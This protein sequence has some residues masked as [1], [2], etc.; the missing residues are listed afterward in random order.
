[1]VESITIPTFIL[2]DMFGYHPEKN[3]LRNY[4]FK[5]IWPESAGTTNVVQSLILNNASQLELRYW[6]M[7]V[8]FLGSEWLI[9]E[10]HKYG[11]LLSVWRAVRTWPCPWTELGFYKRWVWLGAPHT[12]SLFPC[13]P[14]GWSDHTIGAAAGIFFF[15]I[16]QSG[17]SLPS[18]MCLAACCL[19]FPP[20]LLLSCPL[21]LCLLSLT[22]L[23][24]RKVVQR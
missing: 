15:L 12:S 6:K 17:K 20:I 2:L 24:G 3:A 10:H 1:M 21:L 9:T 16:P 23:V 11:I 13:S 8:K 14:L 4:P 7:S 5:R 19:P 22:D 18:L